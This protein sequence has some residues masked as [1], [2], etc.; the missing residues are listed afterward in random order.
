MRI[1]TKQLCSNGL[2]VVFGRRCREH[3][4]EFLVNGMIVRFL[5]DCSKKHLEDMDGRK[6]PPVHLLV[7]TAVATPPATP[8]PPLEIGEDSA[9]EEDP[10][11][12]T[13]VLMDDTYFPHP[14]ECMCSRCVDRAADEAEYQR[15]FKCDPKKKSVSTCDCWNCTPERITSVFIGPHNITCTCSVECQLASILGS[16][17]TAFWQNLSANSEHVPLVPEQVYHGGLLTEVPAHEYI[18]DH[19]LPVFRPERGFP[20]GR[21][22]DAAIKRLLQVESRDIG[23]YLKLQAAASRW[24]FGKRWTIDNIGKLLRYID[25][26]IEVEHYQISYLDRQIICSKLIYTLSKV[27][28]QENVL[29]TVLNN[30][31]DAQEMLLRDALVRGQL[32]PSVTFGA[33]A[34][35]LLTLGAWRS[36]KRDVVLPRA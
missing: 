7:E 24:M 33:R 26:V 22:N 6:T 16:S 4:S 5:K 36:W 27:H 30:K 2:T 8:E 32:D 3:D 28:G 13:I 21:M 18:D 12:D 11:Y 20:V 9:K 35:E 14:W 1:I 29:V 17:E 25:E 31:R 10:A 15:R 34:L 23:L 19:F